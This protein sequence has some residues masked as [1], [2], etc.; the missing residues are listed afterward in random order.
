MDKRRALRAGWVR[1]DCGETLNTF[2]SMSR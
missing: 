2:W 1:V